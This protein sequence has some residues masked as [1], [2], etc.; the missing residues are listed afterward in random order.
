MSAYISDFDASHFPYITTLDNSL[1]VI[2]EMFQDEGAK[3]E[4]TSAPNTGTFYGGGFFSFFSGTSYAYSSAQAPGHAFVATGDLHYFFPPFSGHKGDGPTSH[5]LWGTL[6]SLTLGAG[7]DKGGHILDPFITFVFDEPL[8]GDV[9]DGRENVTHDIMWG[10]MNGSVEGATDSIGTVP[11]GGLMA[12]LETNGLD[13][14]MSIADLVG[15]N[16]ATETDLA[17]AA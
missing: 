10:L 7:V 11:H 5:T 13:V 4:H 3:G 2:L 12:A 8:H 6:D 16:F 15:H 14:D 1:R 9:A 17:L